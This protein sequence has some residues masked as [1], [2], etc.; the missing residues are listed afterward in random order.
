MTYIYVCDQANVSP[1][2]S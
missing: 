1:V 2:C